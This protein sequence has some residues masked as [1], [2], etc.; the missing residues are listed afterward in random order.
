MTKFQLVKLN[1]LNVKLKALYEEANC[2]KSDIEFIRFIGGNGT[3][4]EKRK[5]QLINCIENTNKT[6]SK[7]ERI[8]DQENDEVTKTILYMRYIKGLTFQDISDS[9]NYSISFISK[10]LLKYRDC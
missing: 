7:I 2:L 8:I 1:V 9:I 3:L 4:S 5:R 6:K 10:K